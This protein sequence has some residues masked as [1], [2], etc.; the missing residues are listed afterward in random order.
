LG[1]SGFW[2]NTVNVKSK[3]KNKN[4]FFIYS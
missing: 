2:A 1:I 3:N 4:S